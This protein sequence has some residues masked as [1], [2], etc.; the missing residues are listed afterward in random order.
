[1][2]RCNLDAFPRQLT[3]LLI[4]GVKKGGTNAKAGFLSCFN[5]VRLEER[6]RTDTASSVWSAGEKVRATDRNNS[7]K[8]ASCSCAQGF[9]A[10]LTGAPVKYIVPKQFFFFFL[11]LP[12]TLP[13]DFYQQHSIWTR[14]PA[15][16]FSHNLSNLW[17][18]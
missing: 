14:S 17:T 2:G 12:L 10:W 1:M 4:L 3:Q 9:S 16:I 13:V 15:P 11:L 8:P 7:R 5:S 18:A 6:H